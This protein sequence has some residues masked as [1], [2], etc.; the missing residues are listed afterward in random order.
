MRV[1]IAVVAKLTGTLSGT[2]SGNVHRLDAQGGPV[3]ADDFDRRA[4][5]EVRANNQPHAIAHARLA[6]TIDDRF[7][8]R[9]AL[10]DK[11]V[12]ATVQALVAYR[13]DAL[14]P[15]TD[16][17]PVGET[18]HESEHAEHDGLGQCAHLRHDEY[19]AAHD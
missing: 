12:A 10:P 1:L 8:Q 5:R 3:D 14:E 11:L 6:A 13:H 9:E 19:E 2:A 18:R 7:A 15:R 4:Q 17:L 16:E